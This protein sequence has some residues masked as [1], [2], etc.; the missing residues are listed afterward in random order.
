MAEREG[1]SKTQC[2]HYNLSFKSFCYGIAILWCSEHLCFKSSSDRNSGEEKTTNHT[3]LTSANPT[4]FFFFLTVS[5]GFKGHLLYIKMWAES[6]FP[7]CHFTF[8]GSFIQ[9]YVLASGWTGLNFTFS[10]FRLFPLSMSEVLYG[11]R[12]HP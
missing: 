9:D 11:L 10:H 12:H 4:D 2:L 5:T 3:K 1:D 8:K 6:Q 7:C